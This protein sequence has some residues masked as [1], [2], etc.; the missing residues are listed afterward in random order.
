MCIVYIYVYIIKKTKKKLCLASFGRFIPSYYGT[1]L[2]P[3]FP[4]LRAGLLKKG[5]E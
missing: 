4:Y 3:L 1:E 2:T 5:G